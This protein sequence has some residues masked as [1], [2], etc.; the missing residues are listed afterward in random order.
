MRQKTSHKWLIRITT[1]RYVRGKG[2][3]TIERGCRYS[4]GES[5]LDRDLRED[6]DEIES[7]TLD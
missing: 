2:E 3:L 1:R 6:F 5:G 7:L 4:R